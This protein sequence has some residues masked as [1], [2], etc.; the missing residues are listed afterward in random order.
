MEM[1]FRRILKCMLASDV[2]QKGEYYIIHEDYLLDFKRAIEHYFEETDKIEKL[3]WLDYNT[4]FTYN[5]LNTEFRNIC[6]TVDKL[7]D[8]VNRMER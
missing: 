1:E 5:D 8:K 3:N 4:E 6:N 7:I 2:I